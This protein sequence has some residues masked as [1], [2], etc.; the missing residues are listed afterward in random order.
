MSPRGTASVPA[1]DRRDSRALWF[2]FCAPVRLASV[3]GVTH[4][5]PASVRFALPALAVALGLTFAGCSD[6]SSG[7]ADQSSSPSPETP[8]A[9][10]GPFFPECGGVSEQTVTQL[11]QVPGFVTT[12]RTSVGCQWLVGGSL[13]GPQ[14]SFSWYRGSPIGRERKT[15]ELSRASVEDVA[16]EGHSGWIAIG[17]DPSLGDNLCEIGI[18]FD[19]DFIEWSVSFVA[20]PF[21]DPCGVAKELTRESI[22]ASK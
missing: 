9:V 8:K 4:P 1:W 16:I 12:A 18:Q 7:P 19:D 5:W 17:N 15:E 14:V 11:T 10:H 6:D 22:A 2:C 13:A 3:H 21:P 20:K